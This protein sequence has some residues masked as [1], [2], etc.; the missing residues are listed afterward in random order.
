MS[1]CSS[2]L[3]R[4]RS[5]YQLLTSMDIDEL[6]LVV[7]EDLKIMKTQ[8]LGLLFYLCRRLI[9]R[10]KQRAPAPLLDLQAILA[11]ELLKR[12]VNTASL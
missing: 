12:G 7:T 1:L 3:T 10:Q 4:Q 6:I 11:T 8:Y 5:Y 9:K 2:N